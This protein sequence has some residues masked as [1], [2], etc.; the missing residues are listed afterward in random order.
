[1]KLLV[2][3]DKIEEAKVLQESV[4]DV[5]NI[6]AHFA[7]SRDSALVKINSDEFDLVILDLQIPPNDGSL[8]AHVDHGMMVLETLQQIQPWSA[9]YFFSAFGTVTRVRDILDRNRQ[10]DIFGSGD[11]QSMIRFIEK[12]ELTECTNA[13]KAYAAMLSELEKIVYE[14]SDINSLSNEHIRLLKLFARGLK[15]T[16][17]NAEI[18]TGGKSATKTMKILV[19]DE[20]DSVKSVAVAKLGKSL[21]VKDE[22]DGFKEHVSPIL[23]V[24]SFAHHISSINVGARSYGGNFFGLANQYPSNVY[25]V[26]ATDEALA[27]KVV[28]KLSE[29]EANWLKNAP[30]KHF[31][32]ASLR[33]FFMPDDKFAPYRSLFD[34]DWLTK[35][36]AKEFEL[37][38]CPQH[39]D[40]HGFNVLVDDSSTP[41]L[42]DYVET[43]QAPAALDPIVLELSIWFHPD[44]LFMRQHFAPDF[45]K[46]SDLANYKHTTGYPNFT[47]E[48]RQWSFG[49]SKNDAIGACVT[50]FAFCCKQLKY[51]D[52][53]KRIATKI[54]VSALREAEHL[55]L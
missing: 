15:G 30:S 16:K 12:S 7:I 3:E 45:E 22:L 33:N 35:M 27:C 43:R 54:A 17:V 32:V 20:C 38:W 10:E 47:N 29:Y 13:I 53:D 11:P 34:T 23:P 51:M 9:V 25:Q 5:D 21:K 8:A 50:A 26:L 36:E 4:Q 24:G 46:W 1:M 42:I 40:L 52:A 48:C 18:L 6:Q 31:S 39:G 55:G 44:A 19:R 28:S 49:G 2:V 37:T 14:G 41:L